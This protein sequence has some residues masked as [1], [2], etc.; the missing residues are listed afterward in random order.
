MTVLASLR[1][2]ALAVAALACARAESKPVPGAAAAAVAT[3]ATTASA[4]TVARNA[5]RG[6]I[7]GDSTAKVWIVMISD[8]QCPYCRQWHDSSFAAIR[9]DYV[10]TGKVR[11]AFLNMPLSMHANARPAA[12]AA[13]CASA[14][15]KFWPMHEALF[16]AQESWAPQA[17]AAAA[18][19]S[20]AAHAGVDVPRM[21]ACVNS[22]AVRPLIEQDMKRAADAG[23]KATPSFVIGDQFVEGAVPLADLKRVIDG[24]LAGGAPPA[25]R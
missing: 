11:M 23:A 19:D 15:G 2:A 24:V 10:E 21:R 12:E 22:G 8:F 7:L 17:N 18:I 25:G 16:R 13:M 5:D 4:D 9:R 6:R 20:V 1:A 14:Q 3:T